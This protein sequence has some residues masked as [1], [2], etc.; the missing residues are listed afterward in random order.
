MPTIIALNPR[1]KRRRKKTTQRKRTYRRRRN[2]SRAR[3]AARYTRQTLGGINMMGAA[4]SMVPL[5]VGALAAKFAAKKFAPGGG[6]MENWNWK[7]Y[8]LAAVGGFIAAFGTSALLRKRAAAQKV[9]EGALLLIG[10][11][12]FTNELAPMNQ[13]TE[14]WFGQD[15]DVDP[16][17]LGVGATPGDIWAGNDVDYVKGVDGAWRPMNEM[18]RLP[19]R[20]MGDVM[21][22]PDRRYSGMGDVMVTP[23]RRFGATPSPM[24]TARS[25]DND[26]M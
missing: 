9:F 15:T 17:M 16:Y 20:Q 4:K 24:D 1:P 21:V 3:R 6:E 10:Y 2:P 23:D 7:N 11:K 18:H 25:I 8:A 12:L 14:A 5:V 13:F 22:T 26:M 19:P